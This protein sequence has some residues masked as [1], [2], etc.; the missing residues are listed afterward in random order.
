MVNS[1]LHEEG[2]W[3]KVK[4]KCKVLE[5]GIITCHVILGCNKTTTISCY[6]IVGS[7]GKSTLKIIDCEG[8]VLAE[9]MHKQSTAGVS[10][11]DDVLSLMVEPQIDQSFVMALVLVYRMMNNKL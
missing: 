3:F 4:R 9:V 2:E 8:R 5:R 7:V 11:G 10:L 1:R 6:K